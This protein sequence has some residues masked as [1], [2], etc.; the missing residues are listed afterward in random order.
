MVLSVWGM[1]LTWLYASA[2]FIMMAAFSKPFPLV[3]GL[4]ASGL[5]IV[6]TA[7]TRFSGW[8]VVQL[9]GIQ[10]LG[11][12]VICLRL[13]Y[14][15]EN[16]IHS[17]FSPYWLI[18]FLNKPKT[19]L[20]WLFLFIGFLWLLF[21]WVGGFKIVK[22]P[23]N[24]FFVRNR[25]DLGVGV[26]LA[27]LIIELLIIVKTGIHLQGLRTEMLMPPFFIFGMLA[28][29]L[30]RNSGQGQ[31]YFVPGYSRVGTVL[32]FAAT[33]LLIGTAMVML[34]LPHLTRAAEISFDIIK[35]TTAPLGP[36]LI[37]I[38]LFIFGP[39]KDPFEI[40][41]IPDEPNMPELPVLVDGNES[42]FYHIVG[43]SL[44]SIFALLVSGLLLFIAWRLILWLLSKIGRAHV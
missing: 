23:K 40:E 18:E 3:E 36:I 17:F 13:I 33:I 41:K 5:A 15:F 8:R 11:F 12:T 10:V 38:I 34:F 35:T 2:T 4:T 25:F 28:F 20:Q 29:T 21:F 14:V 6:L 19:L 26:F 27:I 7:F 39:R 32:S 16:S 42:L 24:F 43:W 1:E 22:H 37:K 30:I 31:R 44:F 9:I